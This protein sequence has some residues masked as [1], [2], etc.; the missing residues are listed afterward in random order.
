MAEQMFSG[1]VALVS[2]AARR[3]GLAIARRLAADGALVCVECCCLR[4]SAAP[5]GEG[6]PPGCPAPLTAPFPSPCSFPF[7]SSFLFISESQ[8][9]CFS[10]QWR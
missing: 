3:I 4:G 1:K 6:C 8:V 2:G 9:T 5:F 7:P 10:N